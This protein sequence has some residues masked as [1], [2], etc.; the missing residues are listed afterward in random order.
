VAVSP[1]RY[2]AL[3]DSYTIGTGVAEGERWPNQLVDRLGPD[4]VAIA[5]NLAANGFGAS[6]VLAAQVPRLKALAPQYVS[7]LIGVND[8][9][10][11]VGL[12]TYRRDAARILDEVV[13]L[14]GLT[15]LVVVATPDYTL[16]PAGAEYGDPRRQAARIDAVNA[17]MA[18]LAEER[19]V[20]LVDIVQASRRAAADP[21]LVAPDRLHPSAAQYALWV[22]EIEPVV[23][24]LGEVDPARPGGVS[25]PTRT[26]R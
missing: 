5:A 21:S 9:V 17:V 25:G 3:G 4:R 20:A 14:V 7:I 19:G 8:V 10:R 23:R 18:A 6:D 13:A 22:D 1:L 16:T 24:A 11:G 12:A 2:V 26:T 15:R